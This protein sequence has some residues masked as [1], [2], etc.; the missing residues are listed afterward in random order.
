[1]EMLREMSVDKSHRMLKQ[2]VL[3]GGASCKMLLRISHQLIHRIFQGKDIRGFADPGKEL[4]G[5]GGVLPFD[6]HPA[7]DVVNLRANRLYYEGITKG[8]RLTAA[9]GCSHRVYGSAGETAW[10]S[11]AGELEAELSVTAEALEGA[12]VVLEKMLC[13]STDRDMPAD[14]LKAYISETLDQ[15]ERKTCAGL[16]ESQRAYMSR[17]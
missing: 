7:A 3:G 9:C 14:A 5:R 13:Y 8:S 10:E 11:R 1:M 15:A 17:F 4:A 16:E 12:P 6:Q 2:L